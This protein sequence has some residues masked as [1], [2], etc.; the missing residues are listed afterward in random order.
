MIEISQYYTDNGW[1][2]GLDQDGNAT[3]NHWSGAKAALE[4][5]MNRELTMIEITIL[6]ISLAY[7]PTPMLQ[8]YEYKHRYTQ[9]GTSIGCDEAFR[10]Y[11][12]ARYKGLQLS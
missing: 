5:V 10:L 7:G 11:M 4:E 6:S 1:F 12:E 3:Y 2:S 9:G 8:G